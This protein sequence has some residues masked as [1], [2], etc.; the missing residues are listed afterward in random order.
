MNALTWTL[1]AVGIAAILLKI[2]TSKAPRSR[3][4]VVNYLEN[5]IKGTESAWDWGDFTGVRIADPQLERVRFECLRI[6]SDFLPDARGREFQ[7]LLDELEP[8]TRV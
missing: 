5:H 2:F 4:E 1:A 7:R 3:Q 8:P 6:E